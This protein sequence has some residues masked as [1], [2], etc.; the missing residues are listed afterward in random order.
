MPMTQTRAFLEWGAHLLFN[1]YIHDLASSKART[2]LYSDGISSQKYPHISRILTKDLEPFAV[3]CKKLRLL[4]RLFLPASTFIWII[5]KQH[6]FWKFSWMEF[7][8][9]T[10]LS[11][12]ILELRLIELLCY[13]QEELGAVARSH[14]MEIKR[15][16]SANNL[17]DPCIFL[18]WVLY[19]ILVN[20]YTCKRLILS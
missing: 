16:V 17:L 19:T 18:C 14:L 6:V 4:P 20:Q 7:H 3:Y 10:I 12:N 5:V 13:L 1:L 11:I 15:S 2:F 8:W 9:I